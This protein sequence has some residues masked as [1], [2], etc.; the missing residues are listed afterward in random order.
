VGGAG[1]AGGVGSGGPLSL[2]D[3]LRE[4]GQWQQRVQELE[5]R[6]DEVSGLGE[7]AEG[8]GVA[9]V[10]GAGGGA[11]SGGPLSLADAL[12]ELGQWQQRVQEVEAQLD[13]VSG[14]REYAC[15]FSKPPAPT[16]ADWLGLQC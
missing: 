6:L 7:S 13:E 10:G 16:Q 15:T 14:L 8:P 1:G 2:A 12:R 5:A 11:G 4:L 9:A 3:A